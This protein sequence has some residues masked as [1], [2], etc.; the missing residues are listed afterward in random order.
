MWTLNEIKTAHNIDK[1][2]VVSE[3]DIFPNMNIDS[4]QLSQKSEIKWE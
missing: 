4:L 2:D 1:N 3:I